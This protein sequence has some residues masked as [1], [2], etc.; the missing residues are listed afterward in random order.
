[1]LVAEVTVALGIAFTETT[2]AAL[3]EEHD[4]P[5]ETTN[6]YDPLVFAV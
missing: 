3:I 5:A 6:V 4:P 1:V 2:V